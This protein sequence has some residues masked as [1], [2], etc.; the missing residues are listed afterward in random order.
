MAILGTPIIDIWCERKL[1][2][3]G[4]HSAILNWNPK[5]AKVF[6]Y[7]KKDGNSWEQTPI[8]VTNSNTYE[9]IIDSQNLNIKKSIFY[10]SETV[11]NLIPF[12]NF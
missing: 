8:I 4:T 10:D 11:Y 9:D 7:R 6:I 2:E 1:N 3:D 12:I 5:Y